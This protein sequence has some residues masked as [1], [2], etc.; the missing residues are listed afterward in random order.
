MTRSSFGDLALDEIGIREIEAFKAQRIER[1]SWRTIHS[2]L[3]LLGYMLRVARDWGLVACVPHG[4]QLKGVSAEVRF[5]DFEEAD[6]LLAAAQAEPEWYAMILAGLKTGLRHGELIALRWR[7]LGSEHLTVKRALWRGKVGTP[8]SGK[9]RSV[10]IHP[11]LADVLSEQPR[12]GELIFCNRDG[13]HLTSNMTKE[14]IR[15]AFRRARLAAAGWHTLRHTF[16]SHLVM[17]GVP[18]KVVQE[19]LGHANIQTTMRYAHLTPAMH[20]DAIALL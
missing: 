6:Q 12:R 14:P 7:D 10:P 15:R 13:G 18:L 19:L 11:L 4:R 8:K 17:R 2:H 20:R 3:T 16:A 5:L 9:E 1:L